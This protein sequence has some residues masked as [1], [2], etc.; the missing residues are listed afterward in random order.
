MV[1]VS[2]DRMWLQRSV[3]ATAG[4]RLVVSDSG[5]ILSPKKAPE[6]TAPAAQYSG[7]PSAWAMPM[8]ARPTVPTV[9]HEVPVASET[10]VAR[11]QVAGRKMRGLSMPR[12]MS[13]MVG[14]VPAAIQLAMTMP[15]HMMM[16][17]VGS[18]TF[19]TRYMLCSMSIHFLPLS[20]M[21]SPVMQMPMTSG[22][23]GV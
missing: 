9:P 12:P 20:D 2:I 5:D 21:K 16:I 14:T 22:M 15:T 3:P 10:T 17:I 23:C 1:L 11:M 13:R 6:T 7:T 19:M 4:V 8:M 18:A